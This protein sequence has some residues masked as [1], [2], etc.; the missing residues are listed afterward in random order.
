MV[1]L[2]MSVLG[3]IMWSLLDEYFGEDGIQFVCHCLSILFS[4]AGIELWKQYGSCINSHN[5]INEMMNSGSKNSAIFDEN[6]K[7]NRFIWVDVITAK[8]ATK[9]ILSRAM[10]SHIVEV[11][12]AIDTFNVIPTFEKDLDEQVSHL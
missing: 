10:P 7:V 2:S 3:M 6:E 4:I 8:E 11:L 12:E 5:S 1:F 9:L